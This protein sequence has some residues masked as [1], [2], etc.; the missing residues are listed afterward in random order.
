MIGSII[1]I[2]RKLDSILIIIVVAVIRVV[3]ISLNINHE[4]RGSWELD[5]AHSN[6]IQ[7]SWSGLSFGIGKW[8]ILRNTNVYHLTNRA[9]LVTNLRRSSSYELIVTLRIILFL[10]CLRR[11][12]ILLILICSLSRNKCSKN[13]IILHGTSPC[14]L[15]THR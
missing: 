12:L 9:I 2:H 10:I 14:N 13:W 15:W 5:I 4:F 1:L 8:V 11:V 7:T 3:T 6:I